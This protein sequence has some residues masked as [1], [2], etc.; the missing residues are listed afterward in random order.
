MSDLPTRPDPAAPNDGGSL[1][2][3]DADD[4]IIAGHKYDGIR[5]YDN[6]MPG[7]WIW[8]F[9][10][11]V[12]FAVVYF[13]GIEFFGFVDTYEDDLAEAQ[14]ALAE[15][16]E[17]YAANNPT[18]DTAP[19]ALASYVEDTEMVEAGALNYA[20]VCAA[21][22]GDAGQGLIGPN[23]TDAYWIHGAAPED[24]YEILVVGV[25]EKGMPPWEA[26]L[27]DEERA[28]VTAYV[29]SLRG[30][31]PPNPKE[32]QGELVEGV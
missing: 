30:T 10:L 19:T 6:P 20:A 11:T 14:L 22:H 29:V 3:G 5:E 4:R 2:E 24:I 21:C 28:Q 12:I 18:F 25:P 23:L 27:S 31:D 13:V 7:W 15:V 16:R 1:L 17:T 8:L 32:P 26:A 9:V